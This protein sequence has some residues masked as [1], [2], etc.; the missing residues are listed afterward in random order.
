[1]AEDTMYV[2]FKSEESLKY[3]SFDKDA[4]LFHK[5]YKVDGSQ[6]SMINTISELEQK[7]VECGMNESSANMF[8]F[9]IYEAIQNAQ[10]YGYNE[11]GEDIAVSALFAKPRY[12]VSVISKGK[13]PIDLN[14]ISNQISDQDF[15]KK[16]N[17]KRG[18]KAMYKLCDQLIVG[19]DGKYTDIILEKIN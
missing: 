13:E 14:I 4:I 11:S 1:M 8:K 19:I 6:D 3:L 18:F 7:L 10:Q 9:S 17:G 2:S 12:F 16:Q 15:L 5:L